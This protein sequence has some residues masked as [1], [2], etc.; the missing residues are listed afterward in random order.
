MNFSQWTKNRWQMLIRISLVSLVALILFSSCNLPTDQ[1]NEKADLLVPSSTWQITNSTISAEILWQK[2]EP[3]SRPIVHLG[4]PTNGFVSSPHNVLYRQWSGSVPCD[5][6]PIVSALDLTTGQ[7]AWR[8]RTDLVPNLFPARE[9][10]VLVT[11]DTIIMLDFQ[12]SIIWQQLAQNTEIPMRA[13]TQMYQRDDGLYF[14][15]E[16]GLYHISTQ[17][18]ELL[19]TIGLGNVIGMFDEFALIGVE[20]S[21]IE[22]IRLDESQ[23]PIYTLDFPASRFESA[24]L[25]PVFPVAALHNDILLLYFES[26]A[27]EA[28]QFDTGEALW[29]LEKPIHSI[30]A[31]VGE[32]LALYTPDTGLE[33]RDPQTGVLVGEIDLTR[34]TDTT[35]SSDPQTTS[36]SNSLFSIWLT[37]R[38]DYLFI[39]QVD[40]LELVALRIDVFDLAS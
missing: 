5:Q 1:C 39:R 36:N 9:G 15:T 25:N 26:L 24:P 30:P 33:I 10:Y 19:D 16:S 14:P 2:A 34:I 40:T 18:G 4:L 7:E 37:G 23:R 12:G 38:D 28:Y 27:V 13:F 32:F 29:Q 31:L 35:L 6:T 11:A 8:F 20:G 3:I 17:T 22:V 21:R